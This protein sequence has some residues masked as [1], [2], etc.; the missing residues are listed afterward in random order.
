[1]ATD[2]AGNVYAVGYQYGTGT[3][4]YGSSVTA[5]GTASFSNAVLVKYSS[6]GAA[7]WA[8]S[9]SGGTSGSVFNSVTVD[10]TGNVYAAGFQ[11]GTEIYNYGTSVTATGTHSSQNV[12]LVKYSSSGT[13]QWAR[14]V[15]AGT[16]MSAFC[17]V[18]V[19]G[20]GNV[21]AA[22]YQ[23]GTGT[24]YTYGSGVT[25]TGISSNHNVVLVKYNSSGTAQWA[26]SLSAG[27]GTSV[28]NSVATDSVGNVYAAGRQRGTETYN[29]GNSVTTTGTASSTNAVLVKYSS[30]GTAQWARSVSAG[31]Y[32]SQFAS[33]TVDSA[34]NVYAAGQQRGTE[35]YNYGNG[36]TATGTYSGLN[37]VLVKYSE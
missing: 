27:T 22:G 28:F 11:S 6:S 2:S 36:V 20:T 34:G 9:V 32:F 21:Y 12:V 30:S 25:A 17:S 4:T 26:R 19:D 16:D 33:V 5:T 13:A 31:T 3:Y 24:T 23:R 18:A 29:Y 37:I 1:V 14:S 10:S 8:R 35:T 7:Q 15:S